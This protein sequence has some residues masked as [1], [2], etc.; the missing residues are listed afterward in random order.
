MEAVD[1]AAAAGAWPA[2]TACTA[3][4]LFTFAKRFV[5]ED[6]EG[7]PPNLTTR[8]THI[9][10]PL[11]M[12][13][14]GKSRGALGDAVAGALLAACVWYWLRSDIPGFAQVLRKDKRCPGIIKLP[15]AFMHHVAPCV[16]FDAGEYPDGPWP[17][18]L[19]WTMS[20]GGHTVEGTVREIIKANPDSQATIKKYYVPY[21][22]CWF[23]SFMAIPVAGLPITPSVCLLMSFR[24][25]FLPAY[26]TYSGRSQV[27]KVKTVE[28]MVIAAYAA[29][30]GMQLTA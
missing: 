25:V 3:I 16:A 24:E 15:F 7:G 9:T 14:I 26:L 21:E 28:I 19:F 2:T 30:F 13:A 17:Y 4:A 1:V 8:V 18:L 22:I 23:M 12:F 10:Q 29:I 5:L 20:W 27:F 11:L 6:P